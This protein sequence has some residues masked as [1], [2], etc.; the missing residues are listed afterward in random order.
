MRDIAPVQFGN[1][2]ANDEYKAGIPFRNGEIAKMVYDVR[3]RY[4]LRR[5]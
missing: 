4:R 1:R 5:P 3:G 2:R